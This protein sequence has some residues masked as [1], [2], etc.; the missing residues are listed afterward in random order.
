MKIA[1]V[2][3]DGTT[4]SAHFGRAPFYSVVS[5]E[6]GKVVS[7][8]MRDKLGHA[9]FAGQEAHASGEPDPRGHGFD[10]TSQDRH[11]RMVAA[12]SDCEVLLARGMGAGAYESMKQAG[13]RP[14]VT[15]IES[16][17]DAVAAL[18]AGTLADHPEALH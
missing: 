16:I 15:D 14:V 3:E 17:D 1:A 9:Q 7:R 13:I 12:I 10:Q 2:T 18:L 5:I 4:V 11:V 8:E 6:D